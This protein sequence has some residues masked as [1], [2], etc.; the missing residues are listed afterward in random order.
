MIKNQKTYSD[1]EFTQAVKESPSIASTLLKLKLKPAG[2][3]YSMFYRE[4]KRLNLS[5]DHFGGQAWN[6]GKENKTS[7]LIT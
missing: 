7:I 5:Y 1:E 2:S 4:T 3:N 6:L